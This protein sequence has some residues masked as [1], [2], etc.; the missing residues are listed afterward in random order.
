MFDKTLLDL[1]ALLSYGA[2][3]VDILLQVKRI[4]QT[5]SSRDLS[6]FGIKHPVCSNFNNS[7][8]VRH[9]KRLAVDYR[10]G[11]NCCHLHYLFCPCFILF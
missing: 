2:L 11:D 9:D 7:H 5:K 6:P 10:A 1:L 8:Q 3:N 4:Y